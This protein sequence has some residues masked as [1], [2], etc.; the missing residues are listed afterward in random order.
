MVYAHALDNIL[1]TMKGK[2]IFDRFAFNLPKTDKKKTPQQLI[3]N[4]D[5]FTFSSTSSDWVNKKTSEC[6]TGYLQPIELSYLLNECIN[7][8]TY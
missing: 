1:C 5:E 7:I 4:F 3:T 8:E 2:I 6:L